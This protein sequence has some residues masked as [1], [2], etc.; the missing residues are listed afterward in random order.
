MR[1]KTATHKT[2]RLFL[3]AGYGHVVDTLIYY[4]NALGQIGDVIV[5]MD[6]DLPDTELD[7]I[8]NIPGVINV[9]AVRHGEYDFGSYK[10]GY[11]YAHKSGLLKKYDWVYFVN[12]SVYG[13]FY[14]LGPVLENLESRDADCVGMIDYMSPDNPAHIQSW[15]IGC[16]R[17]LITQPFMLEFLSGVQHHDDKQD[18]V[19]RYEIRMTRLI[20]DHG[21]T[22]STVFQNAPGAP[23]PLFRAPM[24]ILNC[25]I[26]FIKKSSGPI[27]RISSLRLLYQYGDAHFVDMVI[28]DIR[29]RK[30]LKR[31]NRGQKTFVYSMFGIPLIACY[32]L[33]HG[34]HYTQTIYLFNLIP[35][36]RAQIHQL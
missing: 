35:I 29:R 26:P 3:F 6:N 17:G 30:I 14:P 15:F 36:I 23:C 18:I 25:G 19:L 1:T 20:I 13:P 21:F 31:R 24:E 33:C 8:R 9:T 16:R 10:R 4:I 22:Y 7:R 12:D 11:Q 34:H 28:A 32:R 27:N 5:V 2:K